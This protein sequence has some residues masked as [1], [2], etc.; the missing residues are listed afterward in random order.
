M[1]NNKLQLEDREVV[2]I[3]EDFNDITVDVSALQP[4]VKSIWVQNIVEP[5]NSTNARQIINI[6]SSLKSKI[7]DYRKI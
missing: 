2:D 5:L 3:L 1:T 4:Q 6:T 7:I